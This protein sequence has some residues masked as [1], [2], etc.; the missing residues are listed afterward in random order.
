MKIHYVREQL[1][2]LVR[3]LFLGRGQKLNERGWRYMQDDHRKTADNSCKMSPD[4]EHAD[5]ISPPL[6]GIRIHR[7]EWEAAKLIHNGSFLKLHSFII[8][9]LTD[10][11]ACTNHETEEELRDRLAESM[12]WDDADQLTK[13]LMD[14]IP[15]T[16]WNGMPVRYIIDWSRDNRFDGY[17]KWIPVS[18]DIL[19]KMKIDEAQLHETAL[20]NIIQEDFLTYISK[21]SIGINEMLILDPAP[22]PK[23]GGSENILIKKLSWCGLL[24]KDSSWKKLE[25]LTKSSF[26]L[27][28]LFRTRFY[29]IPLTG[30][31]TADQTILEILRD[32]AKA[33]PDGIDFLT[34]R[35]FFFSDG[36][37]RDIL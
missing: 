33:A 27:L 35:I 23:N 25:N 26:Y 7:Y 13:L 20:R 28:P 14:N 29:L 12:P 18:H 17:H 10:R 3:A 32:A 24:L 30:N 15:E 2:L 37:L 22:D 21:K 8:P 34:D 5:G 36:K 4:R 6:P 1:C 19:R 16:K 11:R 9:Y 31:E